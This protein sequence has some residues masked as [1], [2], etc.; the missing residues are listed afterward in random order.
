MLLTVEVPESEL[1]ESGRVLSVGDQASSGS[2]STRP[3]GE[4]LRLSG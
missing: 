2:L 3:D 1:E 4:N